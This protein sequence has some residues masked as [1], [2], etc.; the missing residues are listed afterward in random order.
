MRGYGPYNTDDVRKRCPDTLLSKPV[1]RP[2]D[3]ADRLADLTADLR[4]AQHTQRALA[5]ELS[6]ASERVIRLQNEVDALREA[7]LG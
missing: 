5:D 7:I 3:D 1:S 2:R 6:R 4:S